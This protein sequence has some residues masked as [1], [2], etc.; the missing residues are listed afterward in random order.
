MKIEDF[1]NNEKVI[2]FFGINPPKSFVSF[3]QKSFENLEI[4]ED[5]FFNLFNIAWLGGY[6]LRYP[7]TPPELFPFAGNG[8]DG[9]H[10]GFVIHLENDIE[11]MAGS[12]CPMDYNGVFL[13]GHN[14]IETFETLLYIES[15]NLTKYRNNLIDLGLKIENTYQMRTIRPIPKAKDGWKW[16]ETS[17]GVGIFAPEKYFHTHH[18]TYERA[19]TFYADVSDCFWNL[20]QEHKQREQWATSLYYLKEILWKEWYD[21]IKAIKILSEMKQLYEKL[22]RKHLYDVATQIIRDFEK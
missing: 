17:D 7:G 4:D 1:K 13:L 9:E 14:T 19:K 5:E 8:G 21:E 15:E 22:D 6:D 11:Y 3:L 18:V 10:Y 20:S 12:Y 16:H 2:H